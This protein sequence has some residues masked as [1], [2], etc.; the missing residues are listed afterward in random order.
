MTYT[1]DTGKARLP[2]LP[3]VNA[4][5]P[6]LRNW[7]SAVAERL[8]VRE[9]SRGNPFERAVTLRD[10]EAAT[11]GLVQI[12]DSGKPDPNAANT[13][14]LGNG[15][16]A[17]INIDRFIES[18][19]NTRLFRDLLKRLDDP[20]RFDDLASEIRT[21]LLRSIADEASKRGADIQRVD[22]KIE[23]VNRSL[24]MTVQEITAALGSNAAGI[25]EV[26]ASYVSSTEATAT[27]V[28]QLESSL[29]NYYQ[30]GSTGRVRLEEQLTTQAN[31]V[32]GLRG[33]YTLKIQA[34]GALA[35]FGLAASEVNGVP[36]SAFIIS[37]DKFAIVSPNYSGGLT[38]NPSANNVPFGVDANGI[39][40]NNNVYVRGQ[41]RVDTGGKTLADGL[42]GS[43]D[44]A[45]AGTAWSDNTAR[46]AIWTAL[47]NTG[48]ATTN[49]HLV[50]GD[51]VTISGTGFVET[52]YWT[53][54]AWGIPGAIINGNLL[55]N[56]SVSAGKIDTRGLTIKDAAGNVILGSG[57]G[58]DWGQV[59]GTGKPESGATVGATLGH[60]TVNATVF[61]T[62]FADTTG[63]T[64][65]QGGGAWDAVPD[66]WAV[67]GNAVRLGRA[68]GNGQVWLARTSLTIPF[69][70]AKLYR[71]RTRVYAAPGTAG[72]F[73]FG[74]EAFK[75]DGVTIIAKN[76]TEVTVTSGRTSA[77]MHWVGASERVLPAGEWV[78]IEAF[79]RG[80]G[81]AGSGELSHNPATPVTMRAGTA[82][83][84][85]VFVANWQ[86]QPGTVLVDYCIVEDVTYTPP[87]TQGKI[88]PANA[89]TWIAD[90]AIGN[91]QIAN[92]SITNA[93]IQDAAITSAK[94][95]DAAI[96]SAKIGD[97]EVGTLKIAGNAVSTM[98]TDT[99]NRSATIVV[100]VPAGE[101]WE[102]QLLG[103]WQGLKSDAYWDTGSDEP[104]YEIT[105]G[106][107]WSLFSIV[108][109]VFNDGSSRFPIPSLTRS[110][111]VTLYPGANTLSCSLY[112]P[113]GYPRV[114]TTLIAFVRKR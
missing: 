30:D 46:Q 63:W 94:I 87:N 112:F 68:T 19:R 22:T 91:A 3:A 56:G 64:N 44:I 113:G 10:L 95:Q 21:V 110:S 93:K 103:S 82:Y 36:E 6:S 86:G 73:F 42:R 108:T 32:N 12:T 101:V 9:G 84:S 104:R 79:V 90:A 26:Q 77:P 4:Q 81:G 16:S 47:G 106:V 15:L 7:I 27:K 50:I 14:P 13:I 2:A 54:G 39:Y 83:I 75:S 5:D 85:P 53:G 34:G 62:D 96:T 70:P 35:G 24:A 49:N 98:F 33:Q 69:N 78:E 51:A 1:R 55:V 80:H 28:T 107:P 8:E 18:L 114:E 23:D 74:L 37:A 67:S 57:T 40:L 45:A 20:T 100:N 99:G 38:F 76:G 25:R 72:Q 61:T 66:P 65:L 60:V 11:A 29:G 105:G 41:M 92:A 58:L 31:Y 111:R 48:S 97:A 59:V 88:T 102:A 17:S 43:L 109:P 52:R 71:V 89:S